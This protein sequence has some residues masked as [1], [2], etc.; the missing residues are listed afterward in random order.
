MKLENV[1]PWGRNLEEY[2]NMFQL[3]KE[4]L[5]S[6]ILG[7]G[8]GPSSFNFEVTKLNGNITSIDPIYQFTKDEIQKRI[9][10]TLS[11]VS[12]QLKQNQNDFVWKNIKNVDE[13]INI[14]LTAMS[15]FIKDYEN[16][17]EDKRYFHNELPKLSFENSS[18]DLV[19]S[20][21][22]L[23][24]YSEHFDLQFHIDSILEMCRVS[25]KEVKIFPL[26]DLKNQKSEYLE[27]IL[28][29]LNDR[30]FETKIITTNYEFQKGANEM[31]TIKVHNKYEE[32]N[33]LP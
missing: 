13:L 11:V 2:Q 29:I 10:E 4:D 23:F 24:L 12:E 14:R 17:K 5:Q 3:S 33:N 22:F 16:G 32:T 26:L 9:D 7:C 19:L 18:F 25:K 20:S 27:P 6:K 21:H 28:E 1:V 30:S 15:N 31:L 8:D